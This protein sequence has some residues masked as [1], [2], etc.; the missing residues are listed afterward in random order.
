LRARADI[1]V[2]SLQSVL[3]GSFGRFLASGGFNTLATWLLYVALLPWLKYRVSYT[4]AYASGIALAYV[5]NRYL[6]FRRPGGRA[7]P[8]LVTFIYAGQYLLGLALVVV[9]VRWLR[10]P[11]AL[12]PLFAVALTLPV[13]YV[14]NRRVFSGEHD[15]GRTRPSLRALLPSS[16]A[17]RQGASRLAV[18]LLVGLPLLSLALNAIGWLRFGVDLPF[19]DDWRGYDSGD[20]DSFDPRYLFRPTNDTMT[21][22][23]FALDALAQRWLD[24]NSVA[25]QFLSMVFVLGALLVLQWKLLRA[26]LG[27]SL[28]TAACFVFCLLMLQPGSYWGRENLAYEQALPVVFILCAIWLGVRRPAAA[29]WSVALVFVLGLLAGLSYISGAFGALAAGIGMLV[30]AHLSRE[31]R[32]GDAVLWSG[33]A[34]AAAGM[35]T[36]VVQAVYAILPGKGATH[37]GGK[38]LGLPIEPEYWFFF[39]GKVGR[40]LLLPPELPALSMALVLLACIVLLV[41]AALVVRAAR[42]APA[43]GDPALLRTSAVL[44]ALVGMVLVYLLLVSAGRLHFRPAQ[45]GAGLDIFAFAFDR[46]HFFWATLLWPWL[47]AAGV[48][49]Y[50]RCA[51]STRA[52]KAVAVVAAV[53]LL[54]GV[55]AMVERGALSHVDS[56]RTQASHRKKTVDCLLAELQKGEGIHCPEFMQPDLTPAFIYA[57]A[58][59]A[60]FVRYFP[61]LPVQPGADS[62]PAL[63]RLSRDAQGGTW[64]GVAAAGGSSYRATQDAQLNFDVGHAN[65]MARC[66]MLDVTVVMRPSSAGVARIY[67]RPLGQREFTELASLPAEVKTGDALSVVQFRIEHPFGFESVMRFDPVAGQ[68]GFEL[69]ELEVRCRLRSRLNTLAPFYQITDGTSP[70]ELQ[71]MAP[72]GDVGGHFR[73]GDDPRILFHTRHRVEMASCRLLEVRPIYTVDHDDRGQLYFRPRGVPAFSEEHSLVR[74]VAAAG[75]PQPYAFVVESTAGFEDDLR[76]D[77]VM[78]PQDMRFTDIGVKCLR[79]VDAARYRP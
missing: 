57:R 77:P 22:I 21:P 62:P 42:E 59:G 64:S 46:F 6:V 18:L 67:Y 32:S 39:L 45:L 78:Q 8:L 30:A 74:P 25:Y 12:A 36:A 35:V 65:E 15:Q 71:R 53:G 56:H 40:S 4:L 24:G 50:D 10:G 75:E 48:V 51:P 79:R 28:R 33:I 2:R 47:I 70:G 43:A 49:L 52:R 1:D 9:W 3:T 54:L 14:L 60:S 17:V 20:I 23:G 26:V 16:A 27:D 58:I 41:V 19:F 61:V 69:P 13:T 38:P 37:D 34:L 31:R 55:V 68:Q 29:V 11:V 72:V 44:G 66:V 7:G 63:F 5:M 76:F 73:A